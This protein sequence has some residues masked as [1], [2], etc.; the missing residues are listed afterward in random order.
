VSFETQ[1]KLV[2]WRRRITETLL[3]GDKPVVAKDIIYSRK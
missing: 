3:L 1:R 2:N